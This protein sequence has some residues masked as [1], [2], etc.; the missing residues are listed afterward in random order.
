MLELFDFE[1]SF[2]EDSSF[3]N[4]FCLKR[5]Q[6]TLSEESVPRSFFHSAIGETKALLENCLCIRIGL[7]SRFRCGN[8]AGYHLLDVIA[9]I[10]HHFVL[11]IRA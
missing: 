2:N 9:I 7:L 11:S 10:C 6:G 5:N 1:I 8:L 4:I 3:R